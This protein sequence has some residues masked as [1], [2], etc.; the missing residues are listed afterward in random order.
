MRTPRTTYPQLKEGSGIHG[1]SWVCAFVASPL[2]QGTKRYLDT[3]EAP[4]G[5]AAGG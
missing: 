3:L 4:N 5:G 1:A 2:A